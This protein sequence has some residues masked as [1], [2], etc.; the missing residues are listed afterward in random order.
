MKKLISLTVSLLLLMTALNL[1][2][3]AAPVVD[4][5]TG[6]ISVS[7]NDI[8]VVDNDNK[9][10]ATV[11]AD[12]ILLSNIR[13]N[14]VAPTLS[15]TVNVDK[16]GY[17]DLSTNLHFN[18]ANFGFGDYDTTHYHFWY[19][20][21][22]VKSGESSSNYSYTATDTDRKYQADYSIRDVENDVINTRYDKK[23]VSPIYLN[24]GDNTIELMYRCNRNG[25][26]ITVY[27]LTLT[28]TKDISVI[29]NKDTTHEVDD[30]NHTLTS[31]DNYLYL[32]GKKSD[33]KAPV[34][35]I[36]VTVEQDGFYDLYADVQFASYDMNWPYWF[37]TV[38]VT[39]ANSK[40]VTYLDQGTTKPTDENKLIGSYTSTNDSGKRYIKKACK[41]RLNAGT[42]TVNFS[43]Y[44]FRGANDVMIFLATLRHVPETVFVDR[45]DKI[46]I[47]TGMF[48]MKLA[49]DNKYELASETSVGLRGNTGAP[50][51]V[52]YN[53]LT[54]NKTYSVGVLI[55]PYVL[56][57][58][59]F[60]FKIYVDGK[61]FI[62]DVG[63]FTSSEYPAGTDA[64]INLSTPVVFD[65]SQT[66]EHTISVAFSCSQGSVIYLK[67]VTLTK[68]E[69]EFLIV[70]GEP[71]MVKTTEGN[72]ISYVEEDV[73]DW[74]AP[75]VIHM[76]YSNE[77][78]AEYKVVAP[79]DG[80]YNISIG[81]S[82]I[83]VG[84]STSTPYGFSIFVDGVEELNNP[85]VDTV[86]SKTVGYTTPA[87]G[88]TESTGIIG[89][90]T[91]K[92]G[93]NIIK[94]LPAG[95]NSNIAIDM[96]EFTLTRVTNFIDTFE[97]S[98]TAF[99]DGDTVTATA[100][101]DDAS[102][103]PADA[104]V[105]ILIAKYDV[106]GRMISAELNKWNGTDVSFAAE[107]TADSLTDEIKAFLWTDDL[108]PLKT[109]PAVKKKQQ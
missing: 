42:N 21:V 93:A 10:N 47:S 38:S 17:Y 57:A 44:S 85:S 8:A 29:I 27:S 63:L 23:F 105:L 81:Y 32:N 34:V 104:D 106:N 90:V 20:S 19:E 73:N 70:E 5:D 15:A 9:G 2:V 41:V 3:M 48:D 30:G 107:I 87:Q 77:H 76:R 75:G 54:A 80:E 83:G 92:E 82:V 88:P 55:N 69:P 50:G 1:T 37:Q 14:S 39:D 79:A 78:Y 99:A 13:Y 102:K 89:S 6:V 22:V 4:A 67:G 96:H 11:N 86:G 60:G 43:V 24:E 108:V 49:S 66:N 59:N 98:A 18:N 100:V 74:S 91:L 26:T 62:N 68:F 46:D 45:N 109:V 101:I 31:T 94:I 72:A 71:L 12:S 58:D 95:G 53:V 33:G 52:S 84:S 28:P 64:L 97:L 103:A 65:N 56:A 51:K 35:S 61:E 25:N 36:P 7:V 16:A 40:T